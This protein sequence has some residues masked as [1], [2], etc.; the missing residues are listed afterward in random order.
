MF[1]KI[2][3]ITIIAFICLSFFV[4]ISC[5][6]KVEK[7]TFSGERAY[8]LLVAQCNFGPRPPGT[9]VHDTVLNWLRD[10]MD[11]LAD[12]TIV[13]SFS[14]TGYKGKI[15]SMGNVIARFNSKSKKRVLFCAHWDTRPWADRDP[16]SLNW[17]T[18]ILGA[19]DGASGV[20]VLMHLAEIL[21]HNSPP[22]GVDIVLFDGEDYGHEGDLD[23][24]L[25]GSRY[26]AKNL[27]TN[28]PYYAVLLD[29][30]GDKDLKIPKE[31][32]S[33]RR[34]AP[35]VTDSIWA[36]AKFLGLPAFVDSVGPWMID[37]HHPLAA[38]GIKAVDL[39]D[40]EYPYWHTLEDTPDKCSA[41]S[42]NQIGELILDLIFNPLLLTR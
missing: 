11:S 3:I 33:K 5:A 19:N 1:R 2:T 14:G 27:V 16:D 13:Q 17:E 28:K 10:F 9:A 37:D 41:S 30:I 18:P 26:Y 32:F 8:K 42:L 25:M 12:E 21:K 40:F 38:V 4:S 29:M 24:Y 20:A 23:R 36:R 6:K 34:F 15:L 22:L 39:I 7:P 31:G 35:N